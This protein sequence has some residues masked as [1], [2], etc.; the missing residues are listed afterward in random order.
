[1]SDTVKV[2]IISETHEHEGK[3]VSKGTILDVS[4]ATA[5]HLVDLGAAEMLAPAAA[6]KTIG[7]VE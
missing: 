6:M 4:P 3:R 2:R 7:G 1:M 5:A